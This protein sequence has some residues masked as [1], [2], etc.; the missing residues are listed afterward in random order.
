MASTMLDNWGT[1]V[2]NQFVHEL[3]GFTQKQ[4]QTVWQ[5]Y[6]DEK[7]N[8]RLMFDD[9]GIVPPDLWMPTEAGQDLKLDSF[10]QGFVTHYRHEKFSK[11]LI[12]PEEFETFSKYPEIY[13]AARMLSYTEKLT[14]DY[15][16]VQYINDA[17]T[18]A[19]GRIG[20]DS[21]AL[22]AQHTI[23]G[24]GNV[25]NFFGTSTGNLGAALSPSNVAM[26]V[27]LVAVEKTAAENGR[28]D[29]QYKAT[30][31]VGPSEYRFR[32]R[33]ILDSE[34]KDDTS[35]NALNALQGELSG[36]YI[37]VPY[38]TSTLNWF[39][40][41]NVMKGGLTWFWGIKPKFRKVSHETNETTV[42]L[43]SAYWTA[44][45]SDYRTMFGHQFE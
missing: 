17:F 20:G 6:M 23:K 33:E 35:N 34:Q 21:L 15:Y 22:C 9:V 3:W 40:K 26:Q 18:T 16:A 31:V 29:R 28:I 27:T 44:G 32:F 37:S 36:K 24:G 12:V 30:K 45:W 13:D 7:S 4:S 2:W 42:F 41:T 38:M 14:E 19:N 8:D 25:S 11:R 10:G 43:G 39:V 5:S 1:Q